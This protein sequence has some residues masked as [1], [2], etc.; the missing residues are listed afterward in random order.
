M[1]SVHE[2]LGSPN[3]IVHGWSKQRKF[4]ARILKS[5][6]RPLVICVCLF[7]IRR[8]W[9]SFP[10]K[11]LVRNI[12]STSNRNQNFSRNKQ[13]RQHRSQKP[14]FP[15]LRIDLRPVVSQNKF[16]RSNK[17]SQSVRLPENSR[18]APRSILTIREPKKWVSRE[19][20]CLIPFSSTFAWEEVGG[21]PNGGE[22]CTMMTDQLWYSAGITVQWYSTKENHM[23]SVL[24]RKKIEFLLLK[25][26]DLKKSM[27]FL[28]SV[29][30]SLGLYQPVGGWMKESVCAKSTNPF[31]HYA[32]FGIRLC[33]SFPKSAKR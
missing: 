33:T 13:N 4:S 6:L 31:A 9:M 22:L 19:F 12:V 5:V 3:L 15:D 23:N 27:L 20:G 28:W 1:G 24:W 2:T 11:F 26:I 32:N 25:I 30:L 16:Q 18:R 14:V 7:L 8:N 10:R 17:Q 21:V 29:R